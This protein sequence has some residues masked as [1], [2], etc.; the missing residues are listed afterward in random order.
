MIGLPRAMRRAIKVSIGALAGGLAC[1]VVAAGGADGAAVL[2]IHPSLPMTML[3][4]AIAAL[5]VIAVI[6]RVQFSP[7]ASAHRIAA[8][9]ASREA[10]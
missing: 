9:D 7:L 5:V 2:A 8:L 4:V 3:V 10:A 6:R 1:A